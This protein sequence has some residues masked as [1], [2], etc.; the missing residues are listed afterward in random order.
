MQPWEV[1]TVTTK[2]RGLLAPRKWEG[3]KGAGLHSVD[4]SVGY[5]TH[6]RRESVSIR[7]RLEQE[8]HCCG[9]REVRRATLR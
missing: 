3:V 8:Q 1:I 9:A 2:Q 5:P 4:E 7:V 6:V